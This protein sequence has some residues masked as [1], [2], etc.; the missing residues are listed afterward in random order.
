MVENIKDHRGI[1]ERLFFF[2]F[3]AIFIYFPPRLFYLVEDY[4]RP[5]AWAL[6]LLSNSPILIRIFLG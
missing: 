2:G 3:C 4:E 5:R 6:M 1:I